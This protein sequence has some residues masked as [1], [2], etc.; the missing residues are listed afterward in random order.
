MSYKRY[1]AKT[2]SN[3]AE[4]LGSCR[5][6]PG[7][8]VHV[9]DDPAMSCGLVSFSLKGVDPKDLNELL[10]TIAVARIIF[11]PEILSHN[12][13]HGRTNGDDR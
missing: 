13:C 10:W 3:H 2:D 4:L 8:S 7:V 12:R 1:G 11:G 9:A 6:I 5:K